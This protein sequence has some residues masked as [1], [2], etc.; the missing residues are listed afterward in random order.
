MARKAGKVLV[1]DDDRDIQVTAK[2]ILKKHYETVDTLNTPGELGSVI[3]A[4]TYDIILLDMNFSPGATS[5]SRCATS[6]RCA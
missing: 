3:K 6:C 1:I 5:G 2:M 4:S